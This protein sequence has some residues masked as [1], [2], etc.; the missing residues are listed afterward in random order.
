MRDLK[1]N[2][3]ICFK[4]GHPLSSSEFV[5][6]CGGC[7]L[8]EFYCECETDGWIIKTDKD[9]E[10]TQGPYYARGETVYGL[11]LGVEAEKVIGSRN[12]NL[13]AHVL[14]SLLNIAFRDGYLARVEE[15]NRKKAP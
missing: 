7:D 2:D 11:N 5:S 8:S 10:Q 4:C 13:D 6:I 1:Q 15:L 12:G 3:E 9:K 14:A